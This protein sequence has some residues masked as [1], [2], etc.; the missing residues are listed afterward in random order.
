MTF[1]KSL[2]YL[3]LALPLLSI[4]GTYTG[5]KMEQTEKRVLKATECLVNLKCATSWKCFAETVSNELGQHKKY[6]ELAK[7]F[8]DLKNANNALN[9][10]VTLTPYKSQLPKKAQA[11]LNKYSAWELSSIIG[12]RIDANNK[13]ACTNKNSHA[14]DEL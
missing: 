14:T 3:A 6:A 2:H 8:Q 9:I 5:D 4:S 12:D 13:V 7:V 11:L 1:A 10:G